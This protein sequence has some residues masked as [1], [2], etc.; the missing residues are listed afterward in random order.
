MGRELI[1]AVYS[2][3]RSSNRSFR[4][5]ASVNRSMTSPPEE[6]GSLRRVV[7]RVAMLNL[8]YFGIAPWIKRATLTVY[9]PCRCR[10]QALGFRQGTVLNVGILGLIPTVTDCCA[11]PRQPGPRLPSAETVR[12]ATASLSYPFQNRRIHLMDFSTFRP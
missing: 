3:Q 6:P 8:G 10:C 12:V 7:R 11:G 5:N 9:W 4:A 2:Q 1:H